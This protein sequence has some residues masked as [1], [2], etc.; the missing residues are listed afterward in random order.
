MNFNVNISVTCSHISNN[1]TI[2]ISDTSSINGASIMTNLCSF[3]FIS[4]FSLGK[5]GIDLCKKLKQKSCKSITPYSSKMFLI[6]KNKSTFSC[7]SE[8]GVKISNLWPYMSII[9]GITN[10][11]PTY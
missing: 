5:N 7:I 8:T 4:I 3:S 11:T 1:F 6:P 2:T 10:S 9:T